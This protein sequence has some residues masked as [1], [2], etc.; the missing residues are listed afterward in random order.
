MNLKP[1]IILQQSNYSL[2]YFYRKPV[3]NPAE[4][5]ME[6]PLSPKTNLTSEENPIF[7]KLRDKRN[8]RK[9]EKQNTVKVKDSSQ[10]PFQTQIDKLNEVTDAILA[11][12]LFKKGDS[13]VI[14]EDQPEVKRP[15]MLG[16]QQWQKNLSNQED[17]LVHDDNDSSDATAENCKATAPVMIRKKDIIMLNN[18]RK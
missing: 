14:E 8:K 11:T 6:E 9:F 10:N 4:T 15:E 16:F 2:S 3:E 5:S 7:D 1:S 13:K 18:P 12:D 17:K